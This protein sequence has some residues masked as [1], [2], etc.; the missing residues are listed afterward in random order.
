MGA[1]ERLQAS[2]DFYGFV[3]RAVAVSPRAEMI[4]LDY[5]LVLG[6][7]DRGV[8]L[9]AAF[10]AAGRRVDAYTVRRADA[11]GVAAAHR[12]LALRVDQITTD[13]P[14]GLGAALD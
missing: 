2:G 6:A 9:V 5:R 7:Q 14:E 3:A 12:L 10:H 11:E 8:D 4:Y 1:I 13:D